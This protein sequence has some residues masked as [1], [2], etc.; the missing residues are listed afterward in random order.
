MPASFSLITLN[1]FGALAPGTTRRLL[2]LAQKLEQSAIQVA[3]LQEVQLHSH[4]KLL[5]QA[6]AGYPFH[7]HQPG[8]YS[9]KGGLLTLAR[10][11]IAH[12]NFEQYQ[13]QG[14]WYLPTLMDKLLRKGMLITTFAWGQLPVVVIN[15]HIMANYSADWPRRGVFAQMQQKQLHQ[16]AGTVAQQ[17]AEALVV[18]VGDFNIPRHSALYTDF[19][20][21][22][23]LTDPLAGDTRPTHRPPPGVPTRYSLP[24][25]FI[26]VRVPAAQ[27]SLKIEC[28]LCFLDK[29]WLDNRHQDY[30]SDHNGLK[31]SFTL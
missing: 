14:C 6:S 17:P 20:N 15:T 10:Q 25:D 23:G 21:H 8:I 13:E 2:A 29:V 3:C 7:A 4:Q 19:L 30:L 28:D 22:A 11:P 24:I 5:A 18:V 1:C 16:L 27:P 12:Q 9:P 26:L 31:I